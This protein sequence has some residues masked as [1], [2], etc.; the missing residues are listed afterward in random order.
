MDCVSKP[1]PDDD[2]RDTVR[3]GDAATTGA[4]T[5]TDVERD[6]PRSA[7]HHQRWVRVCSRVIAAAVLSVAVF[8]AFYMLKLAE[9]RP[10][11]SGAQRAAMEGIAL[12][13][14][15]A[16]GLG[17]AGLSAATDRSRWP[18]WA[19]WGGAVLGLGLGLPRHRLRALLLVP[20]A[21][22]GPL[23]MLSLLVANVLG[24]AGTPTSPDLAPRRLGPTAG[25]AGCCRSGCP[26]RWPRSR[27][28]AA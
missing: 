14:A 1:Q 19:G 10:V 18:V 6:R 8:S 20:A 2:G 3:V 21:T 25:S 17:A 15:G 26:R 11:S 13:A 22:V 23:I 5:T 16:I 28:S 7:A 9:R 12:L 4:W 27:S 24:A